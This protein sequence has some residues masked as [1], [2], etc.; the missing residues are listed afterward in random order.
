MAE[1]VLAAQENAVGCDDRSRK[2]AE[3][4]DYPVAQQVAGTHLAAGPGHHDQ[5][6][7][8]EEFRPGD[9]DQ[10]QSQAEDKATQESGD[11]IG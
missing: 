8:G 7:A 11:A 6:V 2:V 4:N 1:Q 10:D 9:N 5:V 3:V